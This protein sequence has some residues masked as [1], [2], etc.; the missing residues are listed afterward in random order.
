MIG[1][2]SNRAKAKKAQYVP[3]GRAKDGAWAKRGTGKVRPS[4][5]LSAHERARRRGM[6]A[7]TKKSGHRRS[8]GLKVR[9]ARRRRQ[10]MQKASR[11]ANR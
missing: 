3:P 8:R 6:G 2:R 5:P 11:R 7:L 9:Q 4:R 1:M 10:L